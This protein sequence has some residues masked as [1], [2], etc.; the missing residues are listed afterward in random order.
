MKRYAITGGASSGKS[1]VISELE[2]R[3]EFV[4]I[5]SAETVARNMRAKGIEHPHIR[6]DYQPKVLDLFL[7]REARILLLRPDR[8]F[9]DRGVHEQ[10]DYVINNGFEVFPKLKD[11]MNNT[12]YDIVFFLEQLD[13]VQE[14]EYRKEKDLEECIKMGKMHLQTYKEFGHYVIKVPKMDD[15][16]DRVD[17][18]LAHC[19]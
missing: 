11:Q 16:T 13:K 9:Y 7:Q 12:F 5:E 14:A 8:I 19:N 1:S 18:I 4:V 15:F 6:E 10:R 17:F 3:K 2:L